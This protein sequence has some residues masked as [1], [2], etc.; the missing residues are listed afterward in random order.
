[1]S[2]LLLSEVAD[3]YRLVEIPHQV[4]GL[5]TEELP[6]TTIEWLV[7]MGLPFCS[8]CL[9]ILG[10]VALNTFKPQPSHIRH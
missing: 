5:G 8:L 6:G 7:V 1:M 9:E 10:L 4:F 3:E 2:L